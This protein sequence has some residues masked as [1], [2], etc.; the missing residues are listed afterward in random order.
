MEDAKIA[1]LID[2]ENI[3]PKYL[4]SILQELDKSGDIFVKRIYGD[5][6]DVL[7]KGWKHHIIDYSLRPVHQF[8]HDKNATDYSLMLDAMEILLSNEKINTFC[9]ASGDSDFYSL[10]VKIRERGIRVIVIGKEN[11]KKILRQA[12]DEF[13]CVEN[14]QDDQPIN[15]DEGPEGLLIRAYNI[16]ESESGWVHL[17]KIGLAIRKIDS[18]FDPR[19][20]GFNNLTTLMESMGSSFEMKDNGGIPP[21]YF[22]KKTSLEEAE[23]LSG[24]IEYF[25]HTYGFIEH[26]T[27][28]YYFY[29]KN[30]KNPDLV[31]KGVSVHFKVFKKPDP[32]GTTNL[33]KNGVARDVEVVEKNNTQ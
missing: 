13:V 11:S 32:S 14:L 7:M 23:V 22:C 1:L 6:T 15:K 3:S 17:S 27:G 19:K 2:S 5:W 18:G 10:A 4:P 29:I 31:N 24:T 8:K 20:Y 30:V 12:C 28:K 25:S 33:E 9:I 16:C 26:K 21:I